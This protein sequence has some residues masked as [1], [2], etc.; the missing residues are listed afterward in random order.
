MQKNLLF[1]WILFIFF[2]CSLLC[3]GSPEL[4]GVWIL[5][6][7]GNQI[8]SKEQIADAMKMAA[9]HN[10]NTVYFN[11]WSRGW[12]LWRS[13]AFHEETGFYTEPAAKERDILQ[14]AIAEA[15]KNGLMIEAWLEYGF[16]A[17]WSGY[18]LAGFPKGPLFAR[19]PEWLAKNSKGSD[20]FPSG[21]VGTFYWLNHNHPDV[22][23]FL[24]G[25]CQEMALKYEITGI[26]LDRIRY[27]CLDCGYD[28]YTVELYKQEHNGQLPPSDPANTQWKRWRANKLTAF[29]SAAYDAIK[30][31]HPRLI[32]SNAPSHYS[33]GDSY[34]AYENFLQDWRSWLNLKKL[35]VAQVQMYVRPEDLKGYIPSALRGIEQHAIHKVFVGIASKTSSFTLTGEET[36]ELIRTVRNSGLKG[37]SFWYY[38]DL[39]KLGYFPIIRQKAYVSKVPV[40]F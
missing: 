14:E 16:V 1:S 4:R 20:Q 32:V 10:F 27:P 22:H 33:S 28:E 30:A 29:Q 13:D 31:I 18:N 9:S 3:E 34:P 25:L 8:W 7:S 2:A 23:Q 36:I 26:E 39:L 35:D 38:D 6:R 37:N 17:W 40:P 24:I 19:H 12:P 11:V 5:P 21:H 15:K